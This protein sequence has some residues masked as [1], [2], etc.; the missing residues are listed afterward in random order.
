MP[1]HNRIDGR[2]LK[3]KMR[4]STEERV[5][6]SFYK[7][8]H[9]TDPTQFRNDLYRQLET[10]GVLGRVYVASEGINGQ[11]SVPASSTDAFRSLLY[12]IPFLNGVRLNIAVQDDGKSFFKLKILV[13][14]KIVA[15]G[16]DDASFD[17]TD[18][19]VH[20]NAEEFNRLADD[21]NTI[22]IDMRNHYESEV[23]H[24]KDAVLPDVDTFREELQV[25]EDL[26]SQH[27]EKN[28]L[29]YCTGGIRCEKGQR[30]D[31]TPG[32]QKCIPAEWRYY[33]VRAGDKRTGPGEQ[34]HRQKLRIRRASRRA[35]LPGY[36]REVSPVR[37]PLRRPH[38]LQERRLPPAL[39]T[40]PRL[41]RKL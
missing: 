24:F 29:M 23:G 4:A 5:T 7:Y 30:V 6:I 21:P 32:F 16:L 25:A 15:D 26:M 27:R 13:R 34:V 38:K 18:T 12:S 37:R 9:I 31:E 17:V 41:R 35:D 14:K 40:M 10:L 28:L 1:L 2:L 33:K 36:H 11:I 22:I 8:H 3:E 20:V 39:Y 19:G